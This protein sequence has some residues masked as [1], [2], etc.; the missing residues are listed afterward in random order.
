MVLE[1]FVRDEDGV[2]TNASDV[3]FFWRMRHWRDGRADETGTVSNT[4]TGTYEVTITPTEGGN[5]QYR[6]E[7]TTP[8]IIEEGILNIRDTQF[9]GQV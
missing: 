7:V 9:P 4:A 1:S 3:D 2:L 6:W 8:N 5:L